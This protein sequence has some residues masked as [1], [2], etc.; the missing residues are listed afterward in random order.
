MIA[1]YFAL[2]SAERNKTGA[3]YPEPAAVWVV[4]PAIW[5]E[6]AQDDIAGPKV[7]Y[8]SEDIMEGYEPRSP[9]PMRTPP[10]ALYGAHSNPRIIAQ[11]GAFM[12]FGLS[13]SPMEV[14]FETD[15]Y[16][17]EALSKLEIPP[18]SIDALRASVDAIGMTESMIYPDLGGLAR[19]LTRRYGLKR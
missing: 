9:Y 8:S 4:D 2:L 17:A 11:R 12:I 1:L 3:V 7:I 14:E 6:H 5:N 19:E 15:E 13:K 10:L 18:A 16:P